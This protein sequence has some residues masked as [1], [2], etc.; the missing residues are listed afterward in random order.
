MYRELFWSPV[1][2]VGIESL[3]LV[4]DAAGVDV[5]SVV[6]AA[7]GDESFRIRYEL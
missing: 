3:R 2:G 6:V 4:E 5:E 7:S 1:G